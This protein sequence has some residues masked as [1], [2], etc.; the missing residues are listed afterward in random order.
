MQTKQ[1][2]KISIDITMTILS[3]ILMGGTVLFPSEKV[4]QILGMCLC[5]LWILHIIL[6]NRWF[7]SIFK[8][9]YSPYRIMQIVVNLCVAISALCLMLS[10]LTMAWFSLVPVGLGLA[11][12]MHLVSSH[13]Y[14]IFMSLHLGLHLGTIIY[15]L[16]SIKKPAD[17]A[18]LTASSRS[19]VA[20]FQSSAESSLS[21]A[22]VFQ[23]KDAASQ[24]Q[25]KIQSDKVANLQSSAEIFQEKSASFANSTKVPQENQQKSKT[26]ASKFQIFLKIILAL[27][28][29]Y[30]IYAFIQRGFWKYVF[31]SQQFF[32]FDLERGYILFALDYLSILILIATISYYFGKLL[33]KK[34]KSRS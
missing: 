22:T 1:K 3:I 19:K 20:V 16:K 23:S 6:N 33:Q 2:I 34:S 29:T 8:G 15:K 28:C 25:V 12:V 27:V 17:S 26:K 31:Y 18:S 7:S 13:W 14:Y 4:H 11:R 10:G 9:K 5:S 21:S 30:G 32:F 24:S